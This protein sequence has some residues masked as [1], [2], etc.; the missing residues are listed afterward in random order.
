M[1]IRQAI[2][3][4]VP[5][6]AALLSDMQA[7]YGSPDPPGGALK[8]AH[9]LTR[10]GERLPFVLVAEEGETQIGRAHV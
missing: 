5:R 9:L 4:D 10:L 8:M 6:L 7:H 2:P 3:A 1:Q